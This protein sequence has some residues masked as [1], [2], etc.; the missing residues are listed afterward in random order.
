MI[1]DI[2]I[3]LDKNV[4]II[5]ENYIKLNKT[6]KILIYV[7]THV[8]TLILVDIAKINVKTKKSII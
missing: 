8:I 2:I 7:N 4:K 6:E 3:N 1:L 5:V